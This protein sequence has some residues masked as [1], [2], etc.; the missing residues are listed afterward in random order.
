MQNIKTEYFYLPAERAVKYRHL[1]KK[2]LNM[3]VNIFDTNNKYPVIYADPPWKTG[4]FKQYRGQKEGG[5][6]S[7]GLPYTTMTDEEIKALPIKKIAADDAVL[8]MWCIDSRIADIKEIMKAWGFDFKAV[9]FVWVKK[10]K[11]TNGTNATFGSYTRRS[12]EFC[13]IGTK[14]RYIIRQKA[15]EQLI[16]EPKSEHSRKPN[17]ARER[18]I[19]IMGEIPKIEL[20][21][22]QKVEGWDCWGNEI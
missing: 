13:F 1:R 6:K 5:Q 18:I 15:V 22:R 9:G 2:R 12:C 7:V 10:A 11:T 20:F 3:K 16:I 14:G 21:A 4:Y 17:T 19:Q 8:F